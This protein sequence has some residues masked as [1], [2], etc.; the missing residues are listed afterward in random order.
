M[1]REV[2]VILLA[3]LICL[4]PGCR[5]KS[6]PAA[7]PAPADNGWQDLVAPGRLAVT[8]PILRSGGYLIQAATAT[9]GTTLSGA[10]LIGFQVSRY[11]VSGKA[12]G[13]VRLKFESVEITKDGKKT[14]E[15][16]APQLPFSM[17]AGYR[18]IRLIYFVRSSHADHNM[19]IA[20]AVNRADLNEFTGRM[21]ADPSACEISSAVSCVWVPLGVAVRVE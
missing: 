8:V 12:D 19:A 3:V 14:V 15:T 5:Q 18:H 6:V 11:T 10:D 2:R 21:T 20:A 16:Q 17:P 9:E 13:R 4:I 7:V 1:P